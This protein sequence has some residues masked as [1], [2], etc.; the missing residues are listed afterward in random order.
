MAE[1]MS[2]FKIM[3]IIQCF[4]SV[5]ITLLAYAMPADS[6]N[7]V[8]VFE[9]P[10]ATVNIQNLS[11][12]VQA[13]TQSSLKTPVIEL[14]A[15][16]F[17]SGNILIDLMLNFFF[18]VPEMIGLI[19]SGFALLFNFDTYMMA[20]VEGFATAMITIIYFMAILQMLTNIRSRGSIL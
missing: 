20:V 15:L 12:K 1:T 8:H 2:F 17:Y 9:Q 16:V 7:Y 6:L 18:A 11:N 14:G 4:F 5:A 10:T 19:F 3:I 13:S